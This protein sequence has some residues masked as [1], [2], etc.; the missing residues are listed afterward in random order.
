MIEQYQKQQE[1]DQQ[2]VL[3]ALQGS[4]TAAAI[5]DSQ[6][7]CHYANTAFA[8]LLQRPLDEVVGRFSIIDFSHDADRERY[9]HAL[10]VSK[11]RF[12]G[13]V[14]LVRPNGSTF[15][16]NLR[17]K[18]T[19]V[20]NE[21]GYMLWLTEI[22]EDAVAER[23]LM[24]LNRQIDTLLRH[25][26]ESLFMLDDRMSVIFASQ[27]LATA[28]GVPLEFLEPGE[29]LYRG[30][31]HL[32]QTGVLESSRT[33]D[34]YAFDEVRDFYVIG[35]GRK[36]E[37]EKKLT[38]DRVALS[39]SVPTGDGGV[40]SSLVDI[41]RLK[42]M[43][44]D[45]QRAKLEA[46]EANETKSRMLTS[47]SHELRTPMNAILGFTQ[48]LHADQE[49]SDEQRTYVR[50]IRDASDH[51]LAL[52]NEFLDLTMIETGEMKLHLSE[53]DCAELL[54]EISNMFIAI[55]DSK[56][57]RLSMEITGE[58]PRPMIG[59]R[60]KILR[61]LVNV[62][63]NAVKFSEGGE[64]IV[65]ASATDRPDGNINLQFSVKDQ[66][67]GIAEAE[68]VSIFEPFRHGEAG[69]NRVDSTGLGLAISRQLAHL[70]DG[71]VTVQSRLG[72]GSEF[73]ISL[74]VEAAAESMS[75]I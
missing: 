40:V 38:D 54:D 3:Q 46:D 16:A 72:E 48:L 17:R 15:A 4:A 66:G 63:G 52:I 47:M 60:S 69:A 2:I 9:A 28:Y 45:L 53:F 30:I 67:P 50:M 59:D 5:F 43:S 51:L 31:R 12:A 49:L 39:I 1:P 33:P 27:Q 73:L 11:G 14:E 42:Q 68:Q 58:L 61:I 56:Q 35:A 37:L 19:A 29:T 36:E 71:D 10:D 13:A 20:Q 18:P 74:K 7:R 26:P 57:L 24:I 8:E 75:E 22:E 44:I 23:D 25:A 62:V 70:M 6:E 32:A 65:S 21:P 64:I 34:Q 41:T 55:V